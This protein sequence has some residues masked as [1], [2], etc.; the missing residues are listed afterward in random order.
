MEAA[1][2]SQAS[3]EAVIENFDAVTAFQMPKLHPIL[4]RK[5]V[6]CQIKGDKNMLVAKT[7]LVSSVTFCG[8]TD[9]PYVLSC[10]PN[11]CSSKLVCGHA[12]SSR[13]VIV[14]IILPTARVRHSSSRFKC[15]KIAWTTGRK[16]LNKDQVLSYNLEQFF[17]LQL[18]SRA[19]TSSKHLGRVE[20]CFLFCPCVGAVCQVYA[21]TVELCLFNR[22]L[23]GACVLLSMTLPWKLCGCLLDM[24]V[25]PLVAVGHRVFAQIAFGLCE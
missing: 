11:V 15:F 7:L 20:A 25:L 6:S 2:I 13:F 5:T 18:C 22:L 12:C 3:L 9:T 10:F 21:D 23:E 14:G 16:L 4:H 19:M 24:T 8:C 17:C 1:C